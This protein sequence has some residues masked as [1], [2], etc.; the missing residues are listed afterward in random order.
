MVEY[1]KYISMDNQ[2]PIGNVVYINPI[3]FTFLNFLDDEVEFKQ[4]FI[5]NEYKEWS[6][7]IEEINL[8]DQ[9]N[10]YPPI[11]GAPGDGTWEIAYKEEGKPEIVCMGYKNY[12][13]KISGV[14]KII[15]EMETRY[16]RQRKNCVK[17]IIKFIDD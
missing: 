14:I 6:K 1:L 15:L 17:Q 12:S 8:Y 13:G 16:R 9:E 3:N 10:Y 5:L 7:K 4:N 11:P 2:F